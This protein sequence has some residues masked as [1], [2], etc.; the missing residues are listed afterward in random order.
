[1][2]RRAMGSMWFSYAL[3][4]A[5]G[6]EDIGNSREDFSCLVS[7]LLGL[8]VIRKILMMTTRLSMFS[9]SP[10]SKGGKYWVL[11]LT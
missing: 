10:D 6:G 7:C 2:T 8:G 1:M 4:E 11:N 3:A 9:P 5:R